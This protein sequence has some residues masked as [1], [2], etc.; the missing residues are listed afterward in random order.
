MGWEYP[1]QL[2][3]GPDPMPAARHRAARDDA[4]QQPNHVVRLLL[5]TTDKS[6]QTKVTRS[7]STDLGPQP[8]TCLAEHSK[9][10]MNAS[11]HDWSD[12]FGRDNAQQSIGRCD[13]CLEA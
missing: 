11:C 5:D 13:A 12:S 1:A 4:G 9:Q 3:Q 2:L 7:V 10:N 6:R 8:W